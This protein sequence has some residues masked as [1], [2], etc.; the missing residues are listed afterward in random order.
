MK[1]AS[2]FPGFVFTGASASFSSNSWN[3]V[4]N[5][6]FC[7]VQWDFI[8]PSG[9]SVFL[10]YSVNTNLLLIC[11]AA[12]ALTISTFIFCQLLSHLITVK[13]TEKFF[14]KSLSFQKCILTILFAFII[15]CVH[16]PTHGNEF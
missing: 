7:T 16:L 5:L 9:Q 11:V 3:T 12:Q 4:P 13:G 10:S 8:L 1:F 15:Y 6:Q 2:G 14:E